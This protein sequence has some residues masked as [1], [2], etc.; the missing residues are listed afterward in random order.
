MEISI[1][2]IGPVLLVLAVAQYIYERRR[3]AKTDRELQE[4]RRVLAE[5][6]RR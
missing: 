3:A 5:L 2:L 6:K 1:K 4:A